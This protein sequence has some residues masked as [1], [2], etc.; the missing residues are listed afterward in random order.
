M[1]IIDS[2]ILCV[3]DKHLQKNIKVTLQREGPHAFLIAQFGW[4]IF[5]SVFFQCSKQQILVLSV[6]RVWG[7]RCAF[8]TRMS[9]SSCC[10]LLLFNVGRSRHLWTYIQQVVIG[11]QV[12][13][14]YSYQSQVLN[15]TLIRISMLKAADFCRHAFQ[16]Q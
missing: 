5:L 1:L 15:G 12:C 10:S 9:H 4:F 6:S 3:V 14:Y 16:S 11:L 2:Y 8:A 13:I 7:S